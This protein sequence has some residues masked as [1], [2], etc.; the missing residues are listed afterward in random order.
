MLIRSF[1]RR[2]MRKKR[3]FTAILISLVLLLIWIL[4]SNIQEYYH[5]QSVLPVQSLTIWETMTF[6]WTIDTTNK[7]P[8]YTHTV[9]NKD[10]VKIFLKSSSVNLNTYEGQYVSLKGKIKEIYKGAPVVDVSEIKIS[11]EGLAIQDNTYVFSKDLLILDFKDQNQLSAKRTEREIEV[12]YGN[13]KIFT[14]E[15]FVCST[16]YKSGNCDQLITDYEK[17][18][19][20]SFDSYRGYTYY[21]HGTGLRTVFDGNQFGYIFKNVED[22]I[23]LDI[24]SNI[25][26]I[27]AENIISIQ[28]KNINEACEFT[29]ILGWE[30]VD[31]QE[32]SI[33]VKFNWEK[34]WNEYVCTVNFN[35]Q[36]ERKILDIEK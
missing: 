7:F 27:D 16:I 25:K 10:G 13:K 32:N 22:S 26:I 2:D 5:Q 8:I 20:D 6:E 3:I 4:G 11:N 18:Q 1:Q 12:Y 36:D 24:S 21:K 15:R 28:E 9:Y 14:I 23:L 29:S 19:K 31:K 34:N 30:I 33:R 35:T 17:N